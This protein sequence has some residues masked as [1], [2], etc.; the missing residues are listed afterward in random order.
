MTESNWVIDEEWLVI[1]PHGNGSEYSVPFCSLYDRH[2]VGHIEQKKWSTPE[3]MEQ[4]KRL[5]DE[6]LSR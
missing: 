5:R 3:R 6:V 2:I 4:F 1:D